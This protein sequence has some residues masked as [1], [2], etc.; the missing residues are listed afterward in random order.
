MAAPAWDPFRIGTSPSRSQALRFY[1]VLSS[2]ASW[3]RAVS[4]K[5]RC[6]QKIRRP[7]PAGIR[8]QLSPV[9]PLGDCRTGGRSISTSSLG[10]SLTQRGSG[11]MTESARVHVA[12][13]VA[14]LPS[15][16]VAQALFFRPVTTRP[17]RTLPRRA[18]T[19]S[20]SRAQ[21]SKKLSLRFPSTETRASILSLCPSRLI[22]WTLIEY[23]TRDDRRSGETASQHLP[24]WYPS[25]QC[26]SCIAL[27]C[28]Y[29][30][31]D[32]L[33]DLPPY[34]LGPGPRPSLRLA[35]SSARITLVLCVLFHSPRAPGAPTS[36]QR[37]LHSG[38]VLCCLF[39]DR[40]ARCS[41]GKTSSVLER[42]AGCLDSTARLLHGIVFL[43][44]RT[45]LDI[46]RCGTVLVSMPT[47]RI[48]FSKPCSSELLLHRRF[49]Y[50]HPPPVFEPQQG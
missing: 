27:L 49:L 29:L 28:K 14:T 40:L 19:Q 38:G 12:D 15:S 48:T 13:S 41:K 18:I 42:C 36:E 34:S 10:P 11:A 8:S 21:A 32:Y 50:T 25:L 2:L 44:G 6:P 1:Y 43:S 35:S 26:S 47:L 9:D 23:S 37:S 7:G 3:V 16:L 22:C 4:D 39:P 31:Q 33:Q 20:W 24:S 45:I 46:Y 30:D 5:A 17:S